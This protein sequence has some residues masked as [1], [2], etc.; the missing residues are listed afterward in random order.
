M[1]E[2]GEPDLAGCEN[3]ENDN[4]EGDDKEGDDQEDDDSS[5]DDEEDSGGKL[6]GWEVSGEWS[7]MPQ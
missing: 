7:C 3:P 5:E 4:P 6:P 1:G 2:D